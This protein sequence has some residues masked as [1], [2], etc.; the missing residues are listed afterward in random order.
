MLLDESGRRSFFRLFAR[1]LLV[2]AEEARGMRFVTY[3]DLISASD[4]R[5]GWLI[6]VIRPGLTVSI[7]EGKVTASRADGTDVV[8]FTANE[9]TLLIFNSCNGQFTLEQIGQKVSAARAWTPETG[10]RA[11]RALFLHLVCSGVAES[12]RYWT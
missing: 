7:R 9:T 11:A 6:P 12:C 1:D 4:E 10:F 3:A 8:L 5:L 2:K